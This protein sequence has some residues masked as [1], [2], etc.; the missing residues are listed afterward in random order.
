MNKLSLLSLSTLMFF[1]A[2]N[3]ATLSKNIQ[4]NSLIVYNGNIGLVHEE[5]DLSVKKNDSTIT[6][7][8]VA[9]TIE[10][11][12]VNVKLSNS[13][14]INS[15]Q[16][17]FDKL[18]QA[19]ILNAHIGKKIQVKVLKDTKNFKTINATLLSNEGSRSLVKTTKNAII[20]VSSNDIIFKSIPDE[21]ITKPSLVW[22]I[23]A[24]KNVNTKMEID[25][26]INNIDWK[27]DYI[28]NL[29]KN[30]AELNGWITINNRSGKKFQNTE[31]NVLAGEINRAKKPVSNYR[32][33]KSM[34]V[35][36]APEVSHQAHEG[37]HFYTI[38]FKVNLANNEK[39]Q[40]KFLNKKGIH[41]QREYSSTMNNPLYMNGESEHSVTQSILIKGI[42]EPLPGGIIRSYSTL[43]KQNILLGENNIAHTPKNTPIK[44][45][46][47]KNFD[48][49]VT[50]TVIARD[51]DKRY[52]DA[53]LR[54]S[55]KNSSDE[56]K[57]ITILVPF[58][59]HSDSKILSSSSNKI[60]TSQAYTFT[61]GNL[62][63][64]NIKIKA[65]SSKSFE[66]NYESKK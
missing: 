28:L 63:T 19:K 25:Y 13:I 11:D 45:Q 65:N 38:P 35:Q 53:T 60:K 47:G 48:I 21:L 20:S 16:Y 5:R 2:L 30:T 18:T 37:Y 39:T 3:A 4:N 10:T 34:M 9:N 49:K 26:L 55:I 31:L 42:N 32:Y 61:K 6:Y 66:V 43:G 14:S 50:E 12:S 23:N 33:A 1:G 62:I 22:N 46:V 54:Y 15:Q 27:S 41:V 24:T 58:N 64:F 36:S 59:R 7:E 44:L 56:E 8:G 52:Y 51:D 40:I 29:S 57:N 17:R